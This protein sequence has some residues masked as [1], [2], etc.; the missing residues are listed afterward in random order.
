M[1]RRSILLL[2][3]A[4]SLT[5]LSGCAAVGSIVRTVLQLPRTAIGALTEADGNSVAPTESVVDNPYDP[6]SPTRVSIVVAPVR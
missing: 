1:I 6:D 5:C 3:A 4:F 2:F